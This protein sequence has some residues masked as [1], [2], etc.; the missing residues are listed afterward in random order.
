MEAKI[1]K[2]QLEAILARRHAHRR[3]LQTPVDFA[4]LLNELPKL[5]SAN[6]PAYDAI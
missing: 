1:M 2:H 3:R 6:N 4:A 5:N